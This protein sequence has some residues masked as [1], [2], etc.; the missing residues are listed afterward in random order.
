MI[1]DQTTRLRLLG[2]EMARPHNMSTKSNAK[3]RPT[4]NL[5]EA[6]ETS[7]QAPARE[8]REGPKITPKSSEARPRGGT[9]NDP[10]NCP[11]PAGRGT[12]RGPKT[13]TKNVPL[14]CGPQYILN[15]KAPKSWDVFRTHFWAPR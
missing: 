15:T 11:S 2:A 9:K 14:F 1:D 5:E 3:Q 7:R 6:I 13:G 12:A 10:E 4:E 8:P